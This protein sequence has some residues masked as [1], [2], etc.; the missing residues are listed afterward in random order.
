MLNERNQSKIPHIILI[1]VQNR[2]IYTEVA[3]FWLL[4]AESRG[5]RVIALVYNI[6][7]LIG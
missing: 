2:Q 5:W 4:R 7:F 1:P 3:D 6:F